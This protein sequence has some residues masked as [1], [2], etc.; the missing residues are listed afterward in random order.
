MTEKGLEVTQNENQQPDFED[1]NFID[2]IRFFN[3]NRLIIASFVGVSAVTSAI[4]SYTIPKEWQ[5]SFQIVLKNSEEATNAGQLTGA[6]SAMMMMSR[7]MG[8]TTGSPLGDMVLQTEIKII[9]SPSVLK[10][11]F[12]YVQEISSKADGK[13][14]DY[15]FKSWKNNVFIRQIRGT[16]ILDISYRDK[17]KDLIL[18]VMK[19]ISKTYQAY[20]KREKYD[21]L[22]RGIDYAEE[23]VKIFK[24]KAELSN[25][26]V[27]N[28]ELLH[29]IKSDA[30]WST[31]SGGQNFMSSMGFAQPLANLSTVDSSVSVGSSS[32][33]LADLGKI[34]REIIRRRKFFTDN[35]PTIK[36]LERER[37]ALREYVEISASGSLA[38]PYS[39]PENKESAQEIM[40]KYKEMS[41]RA[42]R[43]YETLENLETMLLNLKLEVAKSRKPWELIST[44]TVND[45]PVYPSKRKIVIIGSVIGLLISSLAVAFKDY[46][47]NK[48]F[49][50]RSLI[51][52]M[53]SNMLLNLPANNYENWDTPIALLAAKISNSV[54]EGSLA[55]IPLGNLDSVQIDTFSKK[56][57]N[58]IGKKDIVITQDLMESKNCASQLLLASPGKIKFAEIETF[59][60]QLEI[61]GQP[62]IG[63][64]MF[65]AEME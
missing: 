56:L 34:N 52:K 40:V 63:W 9:Q 6:G 43:D 62:V 45:A 59:S 18:P 16:Q 20:S 2:A 31:S 29:G 48:V 28:Y 41:R 3:R 1:T 61:Q 36:A 46:I 11:I 21:S 15:R 39:T 7:A 60:N 26:E 30:K 55:L 42:R 25:R 23:Q 32:N 10:P 24:D 35:D 50:S 4:Y 54:A 33:P 8:G 57:S 5:G 64:I 22:K 65:D 51:A 37:D 14:S 38:S 58:F 27:D 44:P 49:R 12:N 47:G 17:N 19:M 13:P 53:P